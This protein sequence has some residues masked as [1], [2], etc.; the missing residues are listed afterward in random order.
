VECGEEDVGGSGSFDGGVC[1]GVIV[2]QL[3][4]QKN[5]SGHWSWESREEKNAAASC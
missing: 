3:A 1:M 4:E 2:S 5:Y